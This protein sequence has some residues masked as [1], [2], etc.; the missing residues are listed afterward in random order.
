MGS[1]ADGPCEGLRPC[2]PVFTSWSAGRVGWWSTA[3]A[4]W[5]VSSIGRSR[6]RHSGGS[7]ARWA[8][9][10]A[11]RAT[12]RGGSARSSGASPSGG[13]AGARI[14][15]RASATHAEV[16]AASAGR[17]AARRPEVGWA[18]HDVAAC[19]PSSAGRRG[20][21]EAAGSSRSSGRKACCATPQHACTPRSY[22]GSGAVGGGIGREARVFGRRTGRS[23]ETCSRPDADARYCPLEPCHV[24]PPGR[25]VRQSV[26]C[27][28]SNA[29]ASRQSRPAH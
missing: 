22:A 11:R 14:R 12:R 5:P 23:D 8:P 21:R 13:T 25:P 29:A 18:E 6:I 20:A 19:R 24:T 27:L 28:V 4:P 3:V 15:R 9:A 10:L 1:R 7:T 26:H 16:V 17:Q 2:V